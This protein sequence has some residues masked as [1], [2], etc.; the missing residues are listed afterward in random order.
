MRIK[1]RKC[2]GFWA[3][4]TLCSSRFQVLACVHSLFVFVVDVQGS[5]PGLALITSATCTAICSLSTILKWLAVV[6]GHVQQCR[7]LPSASKD[8][9]T[10]KFKQY[11]INYI[12]FDLVCYRFTTVHLHK[13]IATAPI[14]HPQAVPGVPLFWPFDHPHPHKQQRVCALL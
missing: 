7:R 2:C 3:A 13:R 12:L 14:G 4:Q 8:S 9:K 1:T 10:N 6:L 11:I 5:P